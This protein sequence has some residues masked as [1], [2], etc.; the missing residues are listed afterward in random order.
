MIHGRAIVSEQVESH[1]SKD[2][3]LRVECCASASRMAVVSERYRPAK[4]PFA[5]YWGRAAT[6]R[7]M[8]HAS[9]QKPIPQLAFVCTSTRRNRQAARCTRSRSADESTNDVGM[10]L[11]FTSMFR[12]TS[13]QKSIFSWSYT[14][15]TTYT[16]TMTS[17]ID[18][19]RSNINVIR[20]WRFQ[21]Q[22]GNWMT[23]HSELLLE[24]LDSGIGSAELTTDVIAF[25]NYAVA[26]VVTR[27]PL[28]GRTLARRVHSTCRVQRRRL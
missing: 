17:T 28:F 14:V 18:I 16:R 7:S 27:P 22:S 26:V 12:G 15:A 19:P 10:C 23:E 20:L 9:C 1:A 21:V 4:S 3:V 11:S 2:T 24:V 6:P 8:R 13:I 25:A 5:L